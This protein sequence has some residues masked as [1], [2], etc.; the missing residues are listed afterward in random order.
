MRSRKRAH[1][2]G[3][4]KAAYFDEHG[5]PEVVRTGELPEPGVL[6]G[7]V[8]I[9]VRAA[10]LNHLD[11]WVRRGIPGLEVPLPHIGGSD[12]AG[13]IETLGPGVGDWHV[14]DRVVVNPATWCGRCVACERGDTCLCREFRIIGEHTP[15]GF[16]ELLTVP[17]SN[18]F[19]IPDSLGWEQAAAAPLTFQTAWRALVTRARLT[20]G[21]VLLVTGGSG[22]VATA[23]IQI[24][25]HLEARV[26][27][28]TSGPENV[29]RVVELGADRGIDRQTEDVVAVIREET[30]GRQADVVLDSVGEALWKTVLRSLAPGGRLVT[31]GATT[32]ARVE[33][34]LRHMFWKQLEVLGS[35]MA[36]ARE[37]DQVMGL[38]TSG[39][40]TPVVDRV[41][42]LTE[43]SDAH[44]VLEEGQVFGKLVLRP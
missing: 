37:F 38:V 23:A 32:G 25:R 10:A 6:D 20:A 19:A 11:L 43:A 12:I 30:N 5:G 22:G 13:E 44:R 39:A 14:G 34:D 31:Y 8:R 26:F 3:A 33:I 1:I 15:G 9:R 2:L 18:L 41:L 27:A 24:G 17:A 21:E 36:T 16:A 4:M 28:L 35:T 42:P 40:L 29:R 7:Q